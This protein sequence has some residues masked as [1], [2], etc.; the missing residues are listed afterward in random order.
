MWRGGELN[1]QNCSIPIKIWVSSAVHFSFK[2]QNKTWKLFLNPAKRLSRKFHE[3]LCFCSAVGS[4]KHGLQ[5]LGADKQTAGQQR[6]TALSQRSRSRISKYQ[7]NTHKCGCF[8]LTEPSGW[9]PASV[10]RVG[11]SCFPLAATRQTAT[12]RRYLVAFSL[13]FAWKTFVT[14]AF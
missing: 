12:F 2:H 1:E 4:N 14:G 11:S 7:N 13:A 6:S 9:G 8:H 3:L 10:P 5:G